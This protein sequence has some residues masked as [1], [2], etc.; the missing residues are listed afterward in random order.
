MN[1]EKQGAGDGGMR[2]EMEHRLLARVNTL[3][4]DL[5]KV[6]GRSRLYAIGLLGSLVLALLALLGGGS[7][8]S[9]AR[10]GVLEAQRIV[11]LGP[12]GQPRGEWGV[13]EEGNTT[14]SMMDLQ[15]RPRLTLT[16]RNAGY[17]G[18]SLSNTAGERRVALG[19]LP[20]ETSSLVFADGAGVP[21]TVLGLVR[22]EAASLVLADAGGVSR[23]GF[24]LDGQG[25][26]SVM[27]PDEGGEAVRPPADPGS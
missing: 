3:E 27:L 12:D 8:P 10:T 25:I 21:R 9:A 11:L 17:P 15:R 5:R 4:R 6:R 24:G 16:V 23:I 22:G 19:L 13:D 18:L 2:E 1:D 26:G 20:D 7:L 14:L